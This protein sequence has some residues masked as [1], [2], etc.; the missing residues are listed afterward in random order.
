MQRVR[1]STDKKVKASYTISQLS[2]LW[3]TLSRQERYQGDQQNLPRPKAA[4]DAVRH[5]WG[6]RGT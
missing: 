2:A 1:E 5:Q 6:H 3:E 4:A